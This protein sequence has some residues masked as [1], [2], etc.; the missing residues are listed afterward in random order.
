MRMNAPDC[1]AMTCRLSNLCISHVTVGALL[2]L[3]ANDP[4]PRFGLEIPLPRSFPG[5]FGHGFSGGE[6]EAQ[7]EK[8]MTIKF[9]I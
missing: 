4:L 2:A 5:A 1:Q 8:N 9:E 7:R 6:Y 3:F